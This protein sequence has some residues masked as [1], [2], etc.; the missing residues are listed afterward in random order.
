MAAARQL[1]LV[2]IFDPNVEG[3]L[4]LFINHHH[5]HV[6]LINSDIPHCIQY[7]KYSTANNS[8]QTKYGRDEIAIIIN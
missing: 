6:R 3:C 8:L 4:L 2:L 5:R 1:Q 7:K